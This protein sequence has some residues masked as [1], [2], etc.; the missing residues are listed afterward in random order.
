MSMPQ[1]TA[2]WFQTDAE[3]RERRLQGDVRAQGDGRDDDHGGDRVGGDVA[4]HHPGVG[5]AE[6]AGRLDVVVLL[7]GDDRTPGDTGDLR[8]AQQHDESDHRPD[9]RAG[10]H[11]EEDQAAQDDRDAE[12]DVCDTGEERV[13]PASEEAYQPAQDAA[14]DRDSDGGADAHGDRCPGPVDGTGV[15]VAALTVEAERVAGLGALLSLA[16]VAVERVLVRD[17]RRPDRDDHQ[18]EDDQGGDDENRVAAQVAPGVGPET[19][20]LLGRSGA[21]GAARCLLQRLPLRHGEIHGR[22]CPARGDR[23]V[24]RLL[25]HSGSSGRV[26]RT[27]GRRSGWPPGRRGPGR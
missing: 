5:G 15:D 18:E 9:G 25:R 2:A 20:G 11:G 6:R 21:L 24:R 14:E 10:H 17:Q 8:P 19:A 12:E 13:P 23:F 22:S 4:D 3:E 16:Q 27:R 26:R 7:G 1:E